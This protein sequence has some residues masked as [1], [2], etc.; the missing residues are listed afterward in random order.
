MR[1][2]RR[3]FYKRRKCYD[4][5]FDWE[6]YTADSY[7]RHLKGDVEPE[8]RA[9]SKP[10]DL[11][12]DASSG[13][14]S[15]QGAPVHPNQLLILEAIG[16]LAPASVHEAGCGGGDHVAAVKALY[17]DISVT[18]GDRGRTQLELAV[19]RHPELRGQ[20][21]LQ[22]ITMPYSKSWPRADLVYTQAVVMHVHTAVSHFVAL[23]NLV[24]MAERFVVLVENAQCHNFVS[25]IQNLAEGGHLAWDTC[26]IY[27]FD[28]S[29]GARAILLSRDKLDR[30][31]L[32]S[33]VELRDGLNPSA[34]RLR[35][36]DEDSARGQFGFPQD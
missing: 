24:A 8:Y 30:R 23:S 36:S 25:D 35:R 34:R 19:Q 5:D 13:S 33:D 1:V 31:A 22:D 10:G 21:G 14:V 6:N 11:V 15:S 4:D 12:F 32:R 27:R 18:G 7:E 2:A 29:T 16:Q 26:F 3:L 28:G 17:P 9:I 20:L